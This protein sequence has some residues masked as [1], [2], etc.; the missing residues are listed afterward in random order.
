MLAAGGDSRPSLPQAGNFQKIPGAKIGHEYS[1][2]YTRQASASA[3]IV[4]PAFFRRP[5]AIRDAILLASKI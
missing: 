4:I 5:S 2:D 1:V 3:L